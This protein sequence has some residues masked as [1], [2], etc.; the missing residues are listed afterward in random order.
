MRQSPR[1]L[2]ALRGAPLSA[3]RTRGINETMSI[4]NEDQRGGSV[5]RDHPVD[6]T[7]VRIA[8]LTQAIL[9]MADPYTASHQE[10]V[11]AIAVAIAREMGLTNRQVT[12]LYF[13]GIVHDFGKIAVPPQILSKPSKL[14]SEE[15]RL[16]QTHVRHT[17]DILTSGGF[18]RDVLEVTSM[19]HEYLDGTG[20]PAGLSGDQITLEAR[21]LTVADVYEAMTAH[22][23]YRP[24]LGVAATTAELRAGSGR[25]FDPV[26]VA[27]L[28][29]IMD[30]VGGPEKLDV[31][32]EPLKEFVTG[33][34]GNG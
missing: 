17:V 22:R 12:V 5:D 21:I 6:S 10:R 28:E 25:R 26:V 32:P 31:P 13:A 8:T 4:S 2:P 15:R 33:C 34:L 30:R 24:S 27:A 16:I 19:H 29:R 20:Y 14:S 1:R 3:D 18:E 11:A 9:K 23:T 7:D